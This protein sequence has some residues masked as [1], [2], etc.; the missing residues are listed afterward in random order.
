MENNPKVL[1]S[2]DRT[3]DRHG[4]VCVYVCVYVN[5]DLYSR[6]RL[7]L[8]IQN[9]E[10]IWIK[11]STQHK[12]LLSDTF[13]RSPSSSFGNTLVTIENNPHYPNGQKANSKQN[14]KSKAI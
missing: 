6:R 14:C 9:M 1:Q 11:V 4:G 13:Y 7:D 8:E 12:K 5:K 3:D 10:G 2:T